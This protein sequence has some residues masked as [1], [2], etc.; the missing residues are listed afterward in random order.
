MSRQTFAAITEAS[1]G[2]FDLIK[3]CI[4]VL[5]KGTEEAQNLN[6]PSSD[7]ELL[8][9]GNRQSQPSSGSGTSLSEN[10]KF[11]CMM[12]DVKSPLTIMFFHG[13]GFT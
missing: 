4:N 8:W 5:G 3:K 11:Q 7:V 12:N 13:G 2:P 6:V 10:E 1:E 9:T